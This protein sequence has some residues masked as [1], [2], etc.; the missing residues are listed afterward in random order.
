[1]AKGRCGGRGRRGSGGEI[2]PTPANEIFE[3]P[4]VNLEHVVFLRGLTREASK[5][6]ET[7]STLSRY[8]GTRSWSYSTI[9]AT[10]TLELKIPL[11]IAL[12][13]PVKEYM[14][15]GAKTL[16]RFDADGKTNPSVIDNANYKL[17]LDLFV[18]ASKAHLLETQAWKENNV[19][20]YNLV[21]QHCPKDL[22]A[23]LRN[24]TKWDATE[25]P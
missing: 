11:L 1:M 15:K 16:D 2:A 9:V 5:F 12:V 4:T 8:V 17:Y 24:H 22:E 18:V 20:V 10:A 6:K 14:M 23:E 13:R 3:A 21:L 7:V 19:R 25:L